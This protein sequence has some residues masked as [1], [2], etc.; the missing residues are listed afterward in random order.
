MQLQ[1]LAGV[2]VKMATPK[3]D[4]LRILERLPD[5]CTLEDI[6]YHIYV[7]QKIEKGLQDIK[8]GRTLSHEEV[9]KLMTK[10]L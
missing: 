9:E 3:E 2:M 7:R 10:W 4:V 8:E 6:Q 5:D 1:Y